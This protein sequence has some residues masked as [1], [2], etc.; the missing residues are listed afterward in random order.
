MVS[1]ASPHVPRKV[2]SGLIHDWIGAVFISGATLDDVL[3]VVRSYGRYKE[4]YR[5]T[6]IDSRLIRSEDLTDEFSVLLVSKSTV[7]KTALDAEFQVSHVRIDDH[8]CLD[9][10]KSTRI[11]EVADYGLT[12]QHTLPEGEGKGLIWRLHSVARF[13]E[14]DG[15]VYFEVEAIALSRDIPPTLRWLVGSMVRRV[16]ISSLMTSPSA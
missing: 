2:P 8:H 11:Q 13:E 1:P 5:P 9:I 14:R 3:R 7:A 16:S 4:F 10:T 12:T 15:G 6:V